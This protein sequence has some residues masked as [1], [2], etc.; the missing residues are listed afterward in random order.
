MP[1]KELAKIKGLLASGFHEQ[2][3]TIAMRL[4]VDYPNSAHAHIAAAYTADRLGHEEESITFYERVLKL[5]FPTNEDECEFIIGFGSSLRNVGRLD[6]SLSVLRKGT[7]QFPMH[8]AL[9]AFLALALHSCGKHQEA[10]T[11]LLTAALLAAKDDGFEGYSRALR[12][13][14]DELLES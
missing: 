13:Y 12:E 8:A 2:A 10:M 5:G 6:D 14:R 9:H 11:T 4:V 7:L 3:Y 1:E